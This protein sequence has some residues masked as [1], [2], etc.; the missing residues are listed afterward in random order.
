MHDNFLGFWPAKA[1]EAKLDY[2]F[3]WNSWLSTGENVD[4]FV[5]TAPT[6]IT[7]GDGNNGA[8]APSQNANIVTCWLFDGSIGGVYQ[9][10]CQ[11]TTTA[12]RI[13]KKFATLKVTH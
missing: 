3:D 8:P 2:Q 12:S 4:T 10:A 6:G 11:I 13:V 9:V 7:L 1:P 5:I